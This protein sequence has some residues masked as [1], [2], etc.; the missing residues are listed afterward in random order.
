[1]VDFFT[2]FVEPPVGHVGL[3]LFVHRLASSFT[4]MLKTRKRLKDEILSLSLCARDF[5]LIGK[6]YCEAHPER[7]LRVA[8][9]EHDLDVLQLQLHSLCL[10]E[11]NISLELPLILRPVKKPAGLGVKRDLVLHRANCQRE[12]VNAVHGH[13][14]VAS[15][16]KW[17]EFLPLLRL[18]LAQLDR[19]LLN[20]SRLEELDEEMPLL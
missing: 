15:K 20:F 18:V 19:L 5:R 16:L 6:L 10:R 17:V 7:L 13:Q 9:V 11:Q 2:T 14:M 3:L 1:M 8:L 4:L 12:E